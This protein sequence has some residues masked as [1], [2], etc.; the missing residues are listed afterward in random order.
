MKKVA[1]LACDYNDG[2][3]KGGG[4]PW[5]KNKNDMRFFKE[6]TIG[7]SN[8]VIVMGRKTME[9]LSEISMFPLPKRDNIVMTLSNFRNDYLVGGMDEV[10]SYLKENKPD[11]AFII[12]GGEIYQQCFQYGFVD[13]ILISRIDGDFDCDTFIDYELIKE[14]YK[15]TE[16][17]DYLRNEESSDCLFIERWVKK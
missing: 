12:G 4:L 7:D 11:N 3:G 16:I 1:I 13:E 5:P 17:F 2:I 15:I 6:T 8:N 10:D 9:S 14:N